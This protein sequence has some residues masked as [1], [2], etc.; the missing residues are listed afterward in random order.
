MSTVQQNFSFSRLPSCLGATPIK[1]ILGYFYVLGN[2]FDSSADM[3]YECYGTAP[4][5][6]QIDTLDADGDGLTDVIIG[7][8]SY[9]S[10]ADVDKGWHDVGSIQVVHG[11]KKIPIH[12]SNVTLPDGVETEI[13]ITPNP[14]HTTAQLEFDAPKEGEAE[15]SIVDLLGREVYRKSM[16]VHKAHDILTLPVGEITSGTYTVQLQ[17]GTERKLS[18]LVVVH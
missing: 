8:P 9:T 2:Q 18:H 1:V 13:S 11:S 14:S 17:F 3:Y 7:M 10:P 15:I 4:W 12:A 6:A 16:P 5:A